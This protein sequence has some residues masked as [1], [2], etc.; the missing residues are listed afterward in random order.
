MHSVL[1]RICGL[2]L[3]DRKISTEYLVDT[4]ARRKSMSESPS[5][6]STRMFLLIAFMLVNLLSAETTSIPHPASPFDHNHTVQWSPLFQ[7]T[8]DQI[9]KET[10]PFVQVTPENELVSQLEAFKWDPVQTMS[11]AS[12]KIWVGPATTDFVEKTNRDAQQFTNDEHHLFHLEHVN[13]GGIAAFGILRHHSEF[14]HE[15][16]RSKT[17]SLPFKAGNT[18]AEVEFFGTKDDAPGITILSWH[19]EKQSHAIQI[20]NKD[21][22]S[23]VILFLPDSQLNFQESIQQVRE[24]L[25][26]KP[27]GSIVDQGGSMLLTGEDVRVPI[28]SLNS[29]NN[30]K[31]ELSGLIDFQNRQQMEI[32][33]ASQAIQFKL[34]ESGAS[35]RSK[36]DIGAVPFGELPKPKSPRSF[37]YDRPFYVFLWRNDAA[38][39]Y[40]GAWIGDAS[41]MT[42]LDK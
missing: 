13:P 35:V 7:C 5:P 12:W 41:G 27:D 3:P 2:R 1:F 38:W 29:L 28:L 6:K 31:N 18:E 34:D 17:R 32:N 8:W 36:T 10:G 40:Y 26:K 23:S 20:H 30:Y 9:K 39:P 14:K 24:L 22:T 25:T 19:P 37:V 16:F 42:L 15:L 33:Q 4:I 11:A 21:T